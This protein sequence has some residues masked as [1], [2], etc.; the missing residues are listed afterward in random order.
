M[1]L[2]CLETSCSIILELI[3][4]L[5]LIL[6]CLLS[7]IHR[8]SVCRQVIVVE[9]HQNR[10]LV[11]LV[12]S[13]FSGTILTLFL[14]LIFYLMRKVLKDRSY[15]F[16]FFLFFALRIFLI[17]SV[18]LRTCPFNLLLRI[19]NDDRIQARLLCTTP[20]LYGISSL[21]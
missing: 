6:L 9:T 20:R 19:L 14:L 13:D 7:Q 17:L 8:C 4:K 2:Y 18:N 12:L 11:V 15:Y 1:T 16:Y 3:G 5:K 21:Q 10:I